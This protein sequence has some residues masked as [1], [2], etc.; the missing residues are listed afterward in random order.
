MMDQRMERKG[1][2]MMHRWVEWRWGDGSINTCI[3]WT[4]HSTLIAAISQYWYLSCRLISNVRI[5]RSH[6]RRGITMGKLLSLLIH[7]ATADPIE[8]VQNRWRPFIL[9]SQ[10]HQA[11]SMGET[12]RPENAFW[13]RLSSNSLETI[14]FERSTVLCQQSYERD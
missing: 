13:A 2:M 8:R 14:Y 4:M 11:I 7:H 5:S 12:R 10:T 9:V 3:K 1:V 6:D